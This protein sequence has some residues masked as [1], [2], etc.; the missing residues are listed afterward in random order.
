L[1]ACQ[2][3]ISLE[4]LDKSAWR[5]TVSTWGTTS[6]YTTPPS[7]PPDLDIWITSSG[8]KLRLS[9]I[10]TIWTRRMASLSASHGNLSSAPWKIINS[11]RHKT[12]DYGSPQSHAGPGILPLSGHQF[13]LPRL[14]P[15]ISLHPDVRASLFYLWSFILH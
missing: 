13:C 1:K 10:P 7:S 2:Q 14:S 9:F 11:L 8:R 4:H 15:A 5:S 3:H 12:V 6:N